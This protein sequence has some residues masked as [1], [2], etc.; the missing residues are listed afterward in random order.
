MTRDE[1]LKDLNA[2]E[3]EILYASIKSEALSVKSNGL[4]ALVEPEN[5][6]RA[7]DT[8]T[9]TMGSII[10]AQENIENLKALI[11]KEEELV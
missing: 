10:R 1:F 3:A 4:R 9:F 8:I 6:Q 2:L 7:M 5:L 11:V